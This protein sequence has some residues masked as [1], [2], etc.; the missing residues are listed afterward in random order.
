MRLPCLECLSVS[1]SRCEC[2]CP[3]IGT[4][5]DIHGTRYK[6]QSKIILLNPCDL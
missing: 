3:F 6:R 1:M 5:T 2:V 4:F